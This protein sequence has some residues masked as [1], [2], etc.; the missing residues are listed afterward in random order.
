MQYSLN[1]TWGLLL[2]INAILYTSIFYNLGT[3]LVSHTVK[4]SAVQD[5]CIELLWDF[6][7]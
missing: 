5:F 2:E 3:V 6:G 1:Q 4:H 7:R